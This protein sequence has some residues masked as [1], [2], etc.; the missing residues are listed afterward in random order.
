MTLQRQ[1]TAVSDSE[2]RFGVNPAF[3]YV[4]CQT[5]DVTREHPVQNHNIPTLT[6]CEVKTIDAVAAALHREARLFEAIADV[7]GSVRFILDYK[8]T[9]IARLLVYH[10]Q[11]KEHLLFCREFERS[12]PS[13]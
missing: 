5:V 8:T 4:G 13:Q 9:H 10:H 12:V 3:P 7:S 2:I 1:R 6:R 11:L